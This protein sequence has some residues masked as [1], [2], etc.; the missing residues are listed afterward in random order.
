MM[1]GLVSELYGQDTKSG[2]TKEVSK[3]LSNRPGF[4]LL[5]KND[6]LILENQQ[7]HRTLD[8]LNSELEEL[9]ENER[10]RERQ[11][12][13]YDL[14]T[15]FKIDSVDRLAAKFPD[16]LR[17][18][19]KI[20]ILTMDASADFWTVGYN[21]T[22]AF[23]KQYPALQ[24]AI[25]SHKIEVNLVAMMRTPPPVEIGMRVPTIPTLTILR[26]NNTDPYQSLYLDYCKW[27]EMYITTNQCNLGYIKVF[28][29]AENHLS[30]SAGWKGK[31]RIRRQLMEFLKIKCKSK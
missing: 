14:I 23:T 27:T 22:S 2:L 30:T 20:T 21:D 10:T 18:R 19:D 11:S 15:H 7:L 3:F 8:S 12:Q 4:E 16:L 1:V 25:K 17:K 28:S 29:E 9:K 24:N 26:G 6:S 31:A 5:Q 13:L